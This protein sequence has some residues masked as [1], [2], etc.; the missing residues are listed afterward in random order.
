LVLQ[1][2]VSKAKNGTGVSVQKSVMEERVK[3]TKQILLFHV[4]LEKFP[5]DFTALSHVRVI[6]PE[7]L[8]PM[9]SEY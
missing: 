9:L 6:I 7:F 3:Q 8:V 1:Y 4:W 2:L 5:N